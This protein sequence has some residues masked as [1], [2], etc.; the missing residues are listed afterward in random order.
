MTGSLGGCRIASRLD[1]S[2]K[3]KALCGSKLQVFARHQ[4]AELIE[5]GEVL[6]S[7][8][9]QVSDPCCRSGPLKDRI[10]PLRFGV[11]E[12]GRLS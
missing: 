9:S 10:R 3:R 5:L 11:V 12:G 7:L 4:A 8:D 1:E 6:L 2:Q